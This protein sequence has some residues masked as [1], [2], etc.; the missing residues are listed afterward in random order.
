MANM[1]GL[2]AIRTFRAQAA[3]H[4]VVRKLLL[5]PVQLDHAVG[6]QHDGSAWF[7]A[8]GD[9]GYRIDNVLGLGAEQDVVDLLESAT[10]VDF[11]GVEALNKIGERIFTLERLFNLKAGLSAKDDSLPKR[12]L[13]E[14][15][16]DGPSKGQVF[17]QDQ[18]LPEYYKLRGWDENG[19]PGRDKLKDLNILYGEI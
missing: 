17:E 1:Q 11:G 6:C 8:V 2:D 9:C 13:K 12:F 18:I 16:P 15:M 7:Q 4:R 5:K 10:G 19:V 14:P 3:E